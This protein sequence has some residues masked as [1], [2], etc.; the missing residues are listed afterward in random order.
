MAPV[1]TCIYGTKSYSEGS[2]ICV[3]GRGLK[4]VLGEW[5]ETGSA[6]TEAD[7]VVDA[8]QGSNPKNSDTPENPA[9]PLAPPPSSQ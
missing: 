2:T 9:S 8:R 6:C 4:C 1:T 5:V 7:M 3:N